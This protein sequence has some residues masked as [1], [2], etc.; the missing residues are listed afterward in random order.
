MTGKQE[1]DD[2]EME[3][4]ESPPSIW[5]REDDRDLALEGFRLPSIASGRPYPSRRSHPSVPTARDG[6][7]LDAAE[8]M[9]R[10]ASAIERTAPALRAGWLARQLAQ[11]ASA[12]ARLDGDWV[13]PDSLFLYDEAPHE[14]GSTG[15]RDTR[16]AHQRLQM[17]AARR[18]LDLYWTPARMARVARAAPGGAVLSG[19]ALGRE[20]A[21]EG[22]GR[23]LAPARLSA[24]RTRHPLVAAG[25]ILAA[26]HEEGLAT[27]AGGVWGRILSSAWLATRGSTPGLVLM[28]ATGFLGHAADYRPDRRDWMDRWFAASA[29]AFERGIRDLRSLER[30]A[31]VVLEGRSRRERAV[32]D[33]LV[34]QPL[35]STR[36]ITLRSGLSRQGVLDVLRRLADIRLV[37][38]V[39]GRRKWLAW[40]LAGV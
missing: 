27:H 33:V 8:R 31:T 38:E 15:L 26:W 11:E 9:G 12:T 29:R 25:E 24:W 36:T 7:A 2:R 16:F 28:P 21:W 23:L 3:A 20:E 4:F 13:H 17:I 30:A 22:L 6:D 5:D 18:R 1:P 10:L 32:L 35:A 37:E 39:T 40:R 34:A 19:S 14:V